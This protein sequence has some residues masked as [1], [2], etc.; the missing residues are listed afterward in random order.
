MNIFAEHEKDTL[1]KY[2]NEGGILIESSNYVGEPA[3]I[4]KLGFNGLFE[5][6]GVLDENISIKI[7][8]IFCDPNPMGFHLISL[9]QFIESF[10]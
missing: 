1:K 10:C 6:I 7:F 3:K 9:K 4:M 5:T 2:L 8:E